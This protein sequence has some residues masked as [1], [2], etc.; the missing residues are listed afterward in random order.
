MI[1]EIII[2]SLAGIVGYNLEKIKLITKWKEIT[3]CNTKFTN[4]LGKTLK[5]WSIKEY[6]GY[7]KLKIELPYGYVFKDLQRDLDIFKEGLHFKSILLEQFDNIVFMNCVDNY[8]HL[9]YKPIKLMPYQLL[10][11]EKLGNPIVVNMNDYPHMLIGGSTGS[12]K[13]RL[14]LCILSNLIYSSS[15]IDLYLLQV[16]KGDL[17]V[18]QDCIQTKC[19]SKNIY[20]VLNSL[21]L[22]ND[23]CLER[24]DLIDNRKG[25]YSIKDYNNDS[26]NKP[27]NYIYVIIE[28]FSFLNVSKGDTKEEKM[29]KN[30]CLKCI[31]TIVNVGRS[32]GIFLITSLQKPTNDSIPTDIKSQLCTRISLYIEDE[33]TARVITGDDMPTK[34]C[35]DRREVIVKADKTIQGFAYTI[36]HNIVINTIKGR[37]GYI[38]VEYNNVKYTPPLLEDKVDKDI[39]DLRR[40]INE[41]DK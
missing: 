40:I 5:I 29:I 20:E 25:Y 19:Y 32:S 41:D 34:L 27:M 4:R 24:E 38:D 31:K 37:V 12:G 18:F 17:G 1:S 22:I 36:D 3:N 21:I 8:E 23:I 13:S 26:N 28:E 11:A 10:I 16:R 30:Q 7:T 2:L 33:P 14:L 6:K 15:S 39:N 9:T 35:R